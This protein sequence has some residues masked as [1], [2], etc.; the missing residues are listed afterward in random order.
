MPGALNSDLL[1]SLGRLTRGLS[2]L[3]WGLPATLLACVQ[4]LKAGELH[5]FGALPPVLA[6]GWLLFGLWELGQFQTQ[7]RVWTG[8]LER[9]RLLALVN[10]GL[11]PFLYWWSQRPDET[12]FNQALL[13]ALITGVLFLNS[14]NLTLCRLTAML[15]DATLRA[16][17]RSF[18]LLNRGLLLLG[19]AVALGYLG[20]RQMHDLP[21]SVVAGLLTLERVSLWLVICLALLPLAVTMALIWKTKE[22]ILH[23]VFGG[24]N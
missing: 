1:P 21:L 16:E 10:C 9:T 20:L 17:T 14:L 5:S 24:K 11:S 19:L 2:V 15:P 6:T 7:E 4:T 22:V 3:F 23:G 8:T 18:T 12:F 13:L